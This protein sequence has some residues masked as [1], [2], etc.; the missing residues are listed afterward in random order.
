MTDHRLR[1]RLA[2]AGLSADQLLDIAAAAL[3]LVP[4]DYS[5]HANVNKTIAAARP[6]PSW[7]IDKVLISPDLCPHIFAHME[8]NDVAAAAACKQW[9]MCWHAMLV[10]RRVLKKQILAPPQHF[11]MHVSRLLTLPDD[12][13]VCL[14]KPRNASRYQAEGDVRVYDAACTDGNLQLTKRNVL[15]LGPESEHPYWSVRDAH[16]LYYVNIAEGGKAILLKL[17]IGEGGHLQ[18]DTARELPHDTSRI[19]GL[20]LDAGKLYFLNAVLPGHEMTVYD[21]KT[22]Q[23]Q[24]VFRLELPPWVPR[25]VHPRYCDMVAHRGH[26]YMASPED[27]CI[28]VMTTSGEHVRRINGSSRMRH[29]LE[30]PFA[31]SIFEERMY[32]LGAARVDDDELVDP[33]DDDERIFNNT[34]CVIDLEGGHPLQCIDLHELAPHLDV[35]QHPEVEAD[36]FSL[37]VTRAG[38]IIANWN[39]AEIVAVPFVV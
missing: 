18:K 35:Y 2:A 22:L 23:H 10:E 37:C 11:K 29:S 5:I 26:F 27:N 21:A 32:V 36:Q 30:H 19:H 4:A 3:N 6:L 12:L 17:S 24:S 13:R 9:S 33:L 16:A 14:L 31:L 8:L 7:A 39:H 20:A 28:I 38:V 15:C 34:L 1:V 25:A